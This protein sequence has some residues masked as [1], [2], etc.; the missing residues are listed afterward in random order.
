LRDRLDP[1]E[2]FVNDWLRD[3]VLSGP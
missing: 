2:T 3:T 1:Q